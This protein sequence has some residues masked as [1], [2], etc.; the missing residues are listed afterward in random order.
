M[1]KAPSGKASILVVEDE[2]LI[3]EDVKIR[4]EY[5]GYDVAAIVSNGE[6]ALHLAE[7]YKP[8]LV[9]MDIILHGAMDGIETSEILNDRFNIP[10]V[11]LTSH[12]DDE[13]LNRVK[14]T[15]PYGYVIKPFVDKELQG[16]IETALYK[17]KMESELKEREIWLATT[18][19]S[20]G[21]AVIATDGDGLIHFMNPVAEHLTGW[22]EVEAKGRR[23]SDVFKT[24]AE[25]DDNKKADPFQAILRGENVKF[26]DTIQLIRRNGDSVSIE[27]NDSPIESDNGEFLGIVVVFKDIS[28]R[29]AKDNALRESQANLE[30]LVENTTDLIWSIDQHYS[31]LTFNER[32]A[33]TLNRAYN[34]DITQGCSFLSLLPKDKLNTWTVWLEKALNNVAFHVEVESIIRFGPGSAEISFNPIRERKKV[35]GV[36]IFLR[37]ITERKQALQDLEKSEERFVSI[38][39]SAGDGILYIDA[40]GRILEANEAFTQ[41]TGI[42]GGGILGKGVFTLAAD[43]VKSE[44]L[45]GIL[46]KIKSIIN[47]EVFDVIVVHFNNKILEISSPRGMKRGGITIII[48]DVTERMQARDALE[49]ERQHLAHRVEERTEELSAANAELARAVRLKD[50]FLASMSHEL[51]TPL[52]AIL[53]MSEALQDKIY[54]DINEK[55]ARSLHTIEESGRHLLSLINDILD[56]SK[57][58]AGKLEFQMGPVAVASVADTSLVLVKQAAKKKGLTIERNI[59]GKVELIRADERRLK[60]I[61]VNLLSNAVKFT[62]DGGHIGLTIQGDVEKELVRFIIWDDGIGIA[63]EDMSRLFQAFVQLDSRLSREHAGTGLGLALVRRLTEMHNGGVQVE[64]ELGKGSRFIV[65]LPWQKESMDARQASV[66]KNFLQE[67]NR[68][69]KA[70]L[71]KILLAE[72]NEDN[73]RTFSDYLEAC[74]YR[75]TIARNGMEALERAKEIQPDLI[76][77]DIQMPGMDGIEAIVQLRQID[78]MIDVPIIAVT[79]LAM[80]GDR[81]RCMSAGANDYLSKPVS[82]KSL[83]KTIKHHLIG[84]KES[85]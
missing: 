80:P 19:G 46:R 32:F 47:G 79:A 33:K 69:S 63:A 56:V 3:A 2:R 38:F 74:E 70:G 9:L 58:E 17:A 67:S 72:D 77:M 59:D 30:A 62:P 12:T 14:L 64:S 85:L 6:E 44:Q 45:P 40:N 18:L 11:Y 31:L 75:V 55:Q 52:N 54:G 37:D 82:L 53:G 65:T 28:E 15:Q 10:V 5:M 61:L 20:I 68:S 21:D 27:V 29:L 41:I 26:A 60:Q 23:A 71:E 49:A 50:E 84:V 13:T 25:S 8:D 83:V 81:E 73:I 22:T 7:E 34:K 66:E 36:S 1:E 39:H 48:H 57:I 42:R 51:R 78:E 16:V 43:L 24:V 4:L 76:L 35:I